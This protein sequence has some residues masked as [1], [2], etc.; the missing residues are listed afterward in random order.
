[1]TDPLIDIL[2]IPKS[3]IVGG[4]KLVRQLGVGGLGIAFE[5]V[6]LRLDRRVCLKF[7]R[8]NRS[9]DQR[10]I[11][12]FET[13]ARA[14]AKLTHPNIVAIYDFGSHEGHPYIVM[15]L[16]KGDS[17]DRMIVPEPK[18]FEF[19]L[20]TLTAV[21]SA[22]AYVHSNG[23]VHR[24]I[25]PSN[26]LITR[27]GVAK[28]A[29]FGLAKIVD[30]DLGVVETG[31]VGTPVFVAPEILA[32]R[33]YDQRADIYSLGV[34]SYILFTGYFPDQGVVPSK[35]NSALPK[36]VD[37]VVGKA[38]APNPTNRYELVSSFLNDLLNAF[39]DTKRIELP[40]PRSS[41]AL[42]DI[43]S[44]NT[45]KPVSEENAPKEATP[46]KAPE[47]HELANLET[48]GKGELLELFSDDQPT[49]EFPSSALAGSPPTAPSSVKTRKTGRMLLF[50]TL[51]LVVLGITLWMLTLSNSS[52]ARIVNQRPTKTTEP[53]PT[54]FASSIPSINIWEFDG[55]QTERAD[56]YSFLVAGYQGIWT[57]TFNVSTTEQ[58][59]SEVYFLP[60]NSRS[61]ELIVSFPSPP[62]RGISGIAVQEDAELLA[63]AFDSGVAEES[64]VQMMD[65]EGNLQTT[66]GQQGVLHLKQRPLG[67]AFYGESL[68]VLI[69]WGD[70]LEIN[71]QTGALVRTHTLQRN[72][73]LRDIA[74]QGDRLGAFGNG[75]FLEYDLETQTVLNKLPIPGSTSPRPTE[76]LGVHPQRPEFFMRPP[77]TTT[78]QTVQNGVLTTQEFASSHL[79]NHSVDFAFSPSGEF[80]YTSDIIARRIVRYR[81]TSTPLHPWDSLASLDELF[82]ADSSTS[83]TLLLVMDDSSTSQDFERHLVSST[84]LYQATEGMVK[85]KL[86]FTDS[87]GEIQI[88]DTTFGRN[89]LPILILLERDTNHLL[90]Q[91][92]ST[93]TL[94]EILA[95]VDLLES[96]DE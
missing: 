28:L 77:T 12:L 93:S 14:L 50:L 63:V 18:E 39:S 43:S 81:L 58:L 65:L 47:K 3:R 16:V 64:F 11:D 91:F 2:N 42:I 78:L 71:P 41:A 60:W 38:L 7:V 22:V 4:Y 85:R 84:P 30:N 37:D 55:V 45:P 29:D 49:P 33:R 9:N 75:I 13:E 51:P 79:S 82:T 80:L 25:K 21:G 89:S 92:T 90:A 88:G 6:Q 69:A 17:L 1:M 56:G 15:E 86:E 96:D 20:K 94:D 59:K 54:P 10:V 23:I 26:V 40:A 24:D 53:I 95:T 61:E 31:G 87:A 8:P 73:Y 36:E 48:L 52:D 70:V 74:V 68:L 32:G 72:A 67:C 76:A 27:E 34:L 62:Q 19:I 44:F 5:A 83:H 35:I 57:A 46:A 66:F